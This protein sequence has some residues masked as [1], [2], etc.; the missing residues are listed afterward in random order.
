MALKFRRSGRKKA[1]SGDPAGQ[2]AEAAAETEKRREEARAQA[3]KRRA[4]RTRERGGTNPL[5]TG[6]GEILAIGR[7]MLRIPAGIA[8]QV[9]ERLGLWILAVWR[10]IRP[11]LVAGL[12]LAGRGLV[13]AER[14]V[15]PARGI[16]VVALAAAGLLAAAQFVDYR[17]VQAG[18]PAYEGVENV[19]PAPVIDG[20]AETA[21][22]AHAYV[23]LIVAVA[24]AVVVVL[25][26][27]GRWRL[28]RSLLCLGLLTVAIAVFIDRPA[29]LDE[30]DTAISFVGA[31]AR[32]LGAFW[33]QIFAGVVI[34]A[35]G[36]LLALNLRPARERARTAAPSRERR[37][38]IPRLGRSRVQGARS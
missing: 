36:P 19:A 28:A 16:A 13:A 7:E 35:C 17:D 4:T 9:A 20:T 6:L 14:A 10:F 27:L 22:S 8:L 24:A 3:K 5:V 2:Q 25:S 1:V 21:G 38:R 11:L 26:M 32:L 31:E 34:A 18:V 37:L 12:A 29:G 30:A 33:V 15:T 23:L